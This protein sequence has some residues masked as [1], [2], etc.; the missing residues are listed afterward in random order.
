MKRETGTRLQKRAEEI[1]EI[2]KEHNVKAKHKEASRQASDAWM[3][4]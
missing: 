3:Q 1:E 2:V 4:R